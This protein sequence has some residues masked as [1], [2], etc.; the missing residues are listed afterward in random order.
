MKIEKYICDICGKELSKEEMHRE[1]V[2]LEMRYY[3]VCD[4]CKIKLENIVN[5][6]NRKC[7][8]LLKEYHEKLKEISKEG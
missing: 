4:E 3:E 1:G 2:A 8:E 5:T 7:E 6:Y